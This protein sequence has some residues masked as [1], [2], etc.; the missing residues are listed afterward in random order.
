MH[1]TII[2]TARIA[3]LLHHDHQPLC[4][5]MSPVGHSLIG[6]SLLPFART[7]ESHWKTLPV[8]ACA[9]VA[10]ANLPDWPIPHWGH[11]RYDVSHSIF[12]NL[13]VIALV[14]ILIAAV[15]SLRR[16]L[17]A[18]YAIF[19]GLAWMSHMVLDSFYN[20]GRGVAILWPFSDGRL[21]FPIPWFRT[22]DKTLPAWH[23][24]NLSVYAYELVTYLPIFLLC[25]MVAARLHRR[26]ESPCDE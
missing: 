20:H 22:L 24:R 14:M 25:V 2:S 3:I 16:S 15:T 23:T 1:R 7:R 21:K 9:F 11:D 5:T 19:G 4:R 13:G 26:A 18:R 8:A 6:L 10:L 12:S 17:P